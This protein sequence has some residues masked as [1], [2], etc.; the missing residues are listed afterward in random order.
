MHN[1]N[2]KPLHSGF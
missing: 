1:N 2:V